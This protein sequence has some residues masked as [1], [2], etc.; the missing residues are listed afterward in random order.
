MA[1]LTRPYF[2]GLRT[3]IRGVKPANDDYWELNMYQLYGRENTGS[4][5][6]EAV[7]EETAAPYELINVERDGSGRPPQD[8][9]RINP[10]GQVPSLKLP[11]GSIMTESAAIAIYLADKHSAAKLSPPLASALRSPFLRWMIY[12]A[13]NVYMSDLR[14]CYCGRYTTEPDEA[15]GVK[16]A[17]VAAM[18][19]EWEVYANALGSK[20][21]T[22]GDSFSVV[23]IYAA[24]LATW[25]LDVPAFFRNHQNVKALYDRVVARPAVARVW[26]RHRVEY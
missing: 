14:I 10:L 22:L 13:A 2:D 23:D 5:V 15:A 16:S 6:V 19:R 17:A 7:L 26:K 24:M 12:L 4:M 11:D 25:N 21:F 1:C 8:Y 20:A 3:K 18:A 9:L